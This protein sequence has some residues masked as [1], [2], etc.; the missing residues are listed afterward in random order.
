[1][2]AYTAL[3]EEKS[4]ADY[5]LVEGA[6]H[7]D[8]FWCQKPVIETVVGWFRANLGASIKGK[9]READPKANL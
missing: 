5:V 6:A 8:I 7:G 4:K 1:M 2:F 9:T 3:K